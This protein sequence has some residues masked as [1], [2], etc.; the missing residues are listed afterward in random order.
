MLTQD[1]HVRDLIIFSAYYFANTI[2]DAY[3]RS[4]VQAHFNGLGTHLATVGFAGNLC[5]AGNEGAT[6]AP[7]LFQAFSLSKVHK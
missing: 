7:Q 3:D 2:T 5:H 6:A 4:E 1:E